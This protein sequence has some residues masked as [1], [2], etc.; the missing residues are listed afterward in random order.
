MQRA[1]ACMKLV[2]TTTAGAIIEPLDKRAFDVN[3]ASFEAVPILDS[4]CVIC[5]PSNL[6]I[7]LAITK[8]VEF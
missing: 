4:Y 5:S 3:I 8:A 1:A 2:A 7:A 6:I